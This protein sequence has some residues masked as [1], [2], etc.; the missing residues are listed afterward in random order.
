MEKYLTTTL[1]T[2]ICNTYENHKQHR[3]KQIRQLGASNET[4]R[5]KVEGTDPHGR[6]SFTVCLLKL[7]NSMILSK[8]L[9]EFKNIQTSWWKKKSWL[10]FITITLVWFRKP[11]ATR[12]KAGMVFQYWMLFLSLSSEHLSL[13]TDHEVRKTFDVTLYDHSGVLSSLHKMN[14]LC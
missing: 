3:R 13:A 2:A 10:S 5:W 7:G 14:H 9:Y 8:F 4:C 6:R 11:W 1:N 12:P